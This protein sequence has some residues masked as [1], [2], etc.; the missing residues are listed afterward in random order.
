MLHAQL[1]VAAGA[2][3][4]VDAIANTVFAVGPLE[5]PRARAAAGADRGLVIAR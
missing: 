3:H 1:A 2:E 4:P 5:L